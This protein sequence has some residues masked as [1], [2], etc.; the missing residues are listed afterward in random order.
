MKRVI[1]IVAMLVCLLSISVVGCGQFVLD[2]GAMGHSSVQPGHTASLSQYNDNSG[3]Y[4]D[5]FT[6]NGVLDGSIVTTLTTGSKQ[7]IYIPVNQ[8]SFNV[9]TGNG[10]WFNIHNLKVETDGSLTFDW[11]RTN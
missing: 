11:T 10:V 6:Y 5:L 7:T 3:L 8:A 4:T 1:I 9:Y 2:K